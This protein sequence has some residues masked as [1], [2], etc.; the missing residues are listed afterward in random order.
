MKHIYA[1][2][3]KI[4]MVTIVLTIVLGMLTYL[5]YSEIFVVSAVVTIAAYIIGDLMI[6]PVSNNTVATICDIVLAAVTIFIFNY[7][8]PNRS[9]S[10][11]DATIAAIVLG[12]GEW[13][14]HK[15]VARNVLPERRV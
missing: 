6:L 8:W 7:V 9:I 15:Y 2:L 4:V 10:F 11:W 14:F 5:S 1:L 13:F 3:I 12:I